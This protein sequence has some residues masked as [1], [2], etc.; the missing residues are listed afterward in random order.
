MNEM[1]SNYDN[2]K[3][4]HKELFN[5]LSYFIDTF[6]I[7]HIIFYG[8]SGTGKKY[9]LNK[10]INKIYK[11]DK[12]Q[13]K[14][15]VM[16]VN[17]AH[18]KGIRFIR[19]ELKFFAKTNI[20]NFN[21]KY[22]KSIILFN[23]EKL[24]MDAQSALRRCIEQFSHNTRFFIIVEN[25]NTLLKPILSRFCNIFIPPPTVNN[26]ILNLHVKNNKKLI[27]YNEKKQIWLK[28]KFK[29]KE[30]INNL[31]SLNKFVNLIYDKGYSALD[32]LNLIKNIN[33]KNKYDY[34]FYFDKIR[35]EFRNEKV[36]MFIYCYFYFMRKNINLENILSM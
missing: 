10:F 31:K 8:P 7:P 24:T 21:G 3:N 1:I 28:N 35:L 33:D 6:N 29:K 16:Y 12:E 34:L 4:I 15:Y 11:N 25:I 14:K 26:K 2:N 17:C 23:A 30:N 9:I 5:K 19:D 13:I 20:Q 36:L 27:N 32:I 22:F 18:S